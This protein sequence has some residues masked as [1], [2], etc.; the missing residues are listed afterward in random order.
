MSKPSIA[1]A[2]ALSLAAGL[3]AAG[4]A[5]A[6]E[7]ASARVFYGDLDLSTPQGAKAMFRRIRVQAESLCQPSRS[8]VIVPG[9]RPADNARCRADAV[10]R[11]VLRLQAPMVTAEY[12]RSLGQARILTAA[13]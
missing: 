5:A 3:G 8:P 6:R 10:Q 1:C 7:P 11:A 4:A 9:Q 2:V 12:D 13:K